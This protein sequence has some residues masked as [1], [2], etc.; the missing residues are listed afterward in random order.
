M[1]IYVGNLSRETTEETLRQAF[2]GHG[3]VSTVNIIKDRDTGESRGFGFV[4]TF[5]KAE[6]Q[7]AISILNGTELSGRLL[8]VNEPRPRNDNRSGGG[9]W[10]GGR[11]SW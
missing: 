4:E 6:A 11:R 1:N 7:S 3:E 5:T 9:G 2:A 8:K 10:S